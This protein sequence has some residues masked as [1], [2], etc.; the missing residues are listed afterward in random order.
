MIDTA[1]LK[2]LLETAART[3]RAPDDDAVGDLLRGRVATSN[4]YH[5]RHR[6]LM[7]L[8]REVASHS[9]GGNLRMVDQ[10]VEGAVI[11][12][13]GVPDVDEISRSSGSVTLNGGKRVGARDIR[14]VQPLKEL[15]RD[16][17]SAS[18]PITRTQVEQLNTA[19]DGAAREEFVT[20]VLAASSEVQSL[21]QAG[22]Q[23]KARALASTVA[24]Q[25]GAHMAP[26]PERDT[27]GLNATELADLIPRSAA[28]RY[29]R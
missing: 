11:E 1:A 24:D 20:E 4:E 14:H 10:L 28:S 27:D 21:W 6:D 8:G 16:T 5:R 29:R 19:L 12:Y 13:G 9:R 17:A 7:K 22:Y 15:L 2:G 26:P 3:G 25:L 23:G 18:Q